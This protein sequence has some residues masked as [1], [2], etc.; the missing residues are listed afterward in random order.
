VYQAGLYGIRLLVPLTDNYDYYHGGKFVF[1]RW[2]N[3]AASNNDLTAKDASGNY[4]VQQFF[5]NS[6]V[7]SDFKQYITYLLTHR[8]QYT[9]LTYA[10]DPT[11]FAY[12]TGNELGGPQFGD[13]NVPNSWT[14]QI[15]SLIKQ[16][17]PNK[18]IVDGTYG[19]NRDHFSIKEIDI[20]SDHYYPMDLGKMQKDI[21]AVQ[22]TN[23]VYHIGEYDWRP[24]GS[25]SLAS[26]FSA[27]ETQMAKYP[28]VLAGDFFWSLFGHN[29]P[30]CKNFARQNDGLAIQYG[31]PSQTQTIAQFRDHF[32][33]VLNKTADGTVP[34]VPCPS[35]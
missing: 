28:P 34:A 29:V 1:L 35:S 2:R 11:I 19:I 6:T 15:A 20:F 7:I 31:N 25:V 32:Y 27:I 33:K 23:R 12:E 21:S 9:N 5:T 26:F 14:Q 18:L 17:A 13:M 10:E 30:D 4:L 24:G 16:L 3:I 22:S 8:N